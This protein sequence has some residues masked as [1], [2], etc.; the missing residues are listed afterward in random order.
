MAVIHITDVADACTAL[1]DVVYVVHNIHINDKQ[2]AC[3][4]EL[5]DAHDQHL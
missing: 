3:N 4:A 1:N 5:T 2:S